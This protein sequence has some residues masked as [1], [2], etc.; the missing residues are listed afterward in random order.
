MTDEELMISSNNYLA[1]RSAISSGAI[2]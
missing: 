2:Y 1:A